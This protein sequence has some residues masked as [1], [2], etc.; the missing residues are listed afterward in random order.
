MQVSLQHKNKL[1]QFMQVATKEALAEVITDL[2]EIKLRERFNKL[3]FYD[4]YPYQGNFHKT[5]L[6]ANQRLLMAANRI[7][8]SYCG[9]AEMA[10]HVTGMYPK[11]WNGRRYDQP[12][13][14]WAGGVS[15]ETTRDIVQY[16]LLGSPDDPEAFGSGAIPQKNIIKTERKPGVPNAKSMALIKHVSGGNSSLFFKAYEMG[17]EKWQ[18]RS[19]DCIWLDEEPSRDIYS[20]AVTRTL[21]KRGMVYMT[22][23]PESGM[24]ETVAS[25]VN[26][27]K[28]GQSLTNATWDDA[29]E[30]IRS[31]EGKQGHL[32]EVVMEQILSS[33]SPHEREMRRYGRPSLGSGLVF[34]IMDEKVIIDP[35]PIE[36]HWPRIAAIDFGW[37]HPTAVVWCAIDNDTDTFY[38]YDCHRE[39]KASPAVHA[40]AIRR[41]PFFIPIAYPHDGNRRDSMGNPGLADQYRGLGCN[42]LLDHFSNPPALGKVSGSNSIEEGIMAMVQS[43][44]NG[45][46]R[47]FSTLSDWFEEF[48]MYHR[49]DSK[50]VPIRDDLM[51]ATRYA[52]QSQ[53]FAVSGEDP[54]WTNDLEYR[55]YGII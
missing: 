5:G 48:R 43:M 17:V 21:D 28:P 29:S 51:S 3:D 6:E 19:V 37:D 4:P 32:S 42:F 10:Y 36:D 18:G 22:F 35:F 31:M 55:Q 24:T 50:V 39:S 33:Y 45:K 54:T 20:Q 47:V 30:R 23:T 34:P 46:F 7:G 27:L 16:E 40:E 52:F 2:R 41:R 1:E 11:W 9:A 26:N 14:A 8:K 13:V 15:N 12:I 49:K 38:V 53:R 44:E 25:F